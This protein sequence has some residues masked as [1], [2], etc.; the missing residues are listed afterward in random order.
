MIKINNLRF[1]IFALGFLFICSFLNAYNNSIEII[2]DDTGVKVFLNNEFQGQTTKASYSKCK[3]TIRD[4]EPGNY[5]IKCLYP[6]CDPFKKEITIGTKDN[7]TV[8]AKIIKKF[9]VDIQSQKGV[10]IYFNGK[11]MGRSPNS[12]TMKQGSY[13]IELKKDKYFTFS[14]SYN[15]LANKVIKKQLQKIPPYSFIIV[16]QDSV[17]GREKV[18]INDIDLGYTPISLTKIVAEDIKVSVGGYSKR[19]DFSENFKYKI[20]PNN[21]IRYIEILDNANLLD[22]YK[23]YPPKPKMLKEFEYKK[24]TSMDKFYQ[25]TALPVIFGV[26]GALIKPDDKDDESTPGG[27]FGI[28]LLIG[29]ALDLG[30]ASVDEDKV[31]DLVKDYDYTKKQKN[32]ENLANWKVEYTKIDSI[33][34]NLLNAE[35]KKRAETNAIDSKKNKSRGEWELIEMGKATKEDKKNAADGTYPQYGF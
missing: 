33:N 16:E 9:K 34:T 11:F 32:K 27:R 6:N 19:F 1:I 5:E 35:N 14:E 3:L 20:R 26:L 10:K 23:C 25:Y 4:I 21:K 31:G 13:K 7:L 17:I 24:V 29:L 18:V 28:G 22:D 8:K 2:S 30:M 15:I 12:F